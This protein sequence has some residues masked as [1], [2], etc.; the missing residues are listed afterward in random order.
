M[1]ATSIAALESMSCGKA[2]AASRVG[3]LP[4]IIDEDVGFLMEPGDPEDIARKINIALKDT[5][6]LKKKG[7]LAR[8]KVVENWS[9]EQ[10]VNEH[11]KIYKNIIEN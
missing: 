10:L 7:K 1:E 3:G 6:L 4:E 8:K 11:F 9:S 5:N 2:L